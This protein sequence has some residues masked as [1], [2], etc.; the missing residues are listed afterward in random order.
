M[1]FSRSQGTCLQMVSETTLQ[2]ILP[3]ATALCECLSI[4]VMLLVLRVLD[5]AV[6]S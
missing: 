3:E 2:G 5:P 1:K 4:A 6:S